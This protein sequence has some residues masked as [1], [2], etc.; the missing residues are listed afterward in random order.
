MKHIPL[1]DLLTSTEVDDD[2][3]DELFSQLG[4]FEPP[5]DMIANIMHTVSQ[6]PRPKPLSTWRALDFLELDFDE[7]Q[8]C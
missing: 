1:D 8:L 6:L 7:S 2:E 4:H 3:I 5:I